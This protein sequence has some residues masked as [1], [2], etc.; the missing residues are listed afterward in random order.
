MKSNFKTHPLAWLRIAAGPAVVVIRAAMFSYWQVFT[1]GRWSAN[2]GYMVVALRNFA[3]VGKLSSDGCGHHVLTDNFF[4]VGPPC[5]L[6]VLVDSNG[7]R[8]SALATWVA[9]FVR[10]GGLPQRFSR[11]WW[12]GIGAGGIVA[13][14]IPRYSVADGVPTKVCGQRP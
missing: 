1:T 10:S 6:G 11:S 5:F 12:C 4:F 2:E 9:V 8:W 13:Q 14:D 7:A 3:A